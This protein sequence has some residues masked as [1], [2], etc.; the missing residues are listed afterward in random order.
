MTCMT[1]NDTH[2]HGSL[3]LGQI[4]LIAQLRINTTV[5]VDLDTYLFAPTVVDLWIFH[6]VTNHPQNGRLA[7]ICPPDDK[8]PET[9]EFLSEV[10]EI[11][12]L[13]CQ[14]CGEGLHKEKYN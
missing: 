8:D 6:S 10:L 7:S 3:D 13:C 11:T 5:C 9:A 12:C 4:D 2:P 1:W 14:H